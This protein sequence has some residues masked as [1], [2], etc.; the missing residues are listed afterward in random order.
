[1]CRYG[2]TE[3]KNTYACFGCRK[4]FKRRSEKDLLPQDVR[5]DKAAICPDC[6]QQMA[7]LGRDLRLPRKDKQEQWQA[8][9]YLKNHKFNFFTCGCDGIGVVPQNLH[10]AYA[11]MEQYRHR[12]AGEV[13]LQ[14]IEKKHQ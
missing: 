5:A 10:Q 12:S 9:A 6:G 7:N 8:I 11:L 13:L 2:Y 4:G 14:K 1:M 3:Y